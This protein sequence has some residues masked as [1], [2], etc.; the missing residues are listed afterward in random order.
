MKC[1]SYLLYEG[2]R[3]IVVLETD[4][5]QYQ[6]YHYTSEHIQ[7]THCLCL[8]LLQRFAFS[9]HWLTVNNWYLALCRLFFTCWHSIF[10]CQQ[11]S[12][13]APPPFIQLTSWAVSFSTTA[14]LLLYWPLPAS[15]IELCFLRNTE[16]RWIQCINFIG[17]KN[18]CNA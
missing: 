12:S 4:R 10:S 1:T 6:F 3:I 16:W 15:C 18:M 17:N 2:S 13:F 14:L 7:V 8:H 11:Q 9:I 5:Y